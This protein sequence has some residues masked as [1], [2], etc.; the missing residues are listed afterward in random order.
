MRID[1]LLHFLEGK[2]QSDTNLAEA[3]FSE[4]DRDG[5]GVISLN[6]FVYGYFLK[7]REI[8]DAITRLSEEMEGHIK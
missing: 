7:Q 6:E 8:K 4:I 3:I 1:E 2:G 5:N